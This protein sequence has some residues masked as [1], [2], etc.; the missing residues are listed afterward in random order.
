MQQPGGQTLNGGGRKPLVPRWRRPWTHVVYHYVHRLGNV[1]DANTLSLLVNHV[2]A[3][4][5]ELINEA[6]TCDDGVN[7][8]Q[9]VYANHRILFLHGIC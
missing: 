3:V 7:T 2:D 9:R 1:S 4:V 5:Y 8:L 6:I